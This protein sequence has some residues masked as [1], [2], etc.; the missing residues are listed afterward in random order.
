MASSARSRPSATSNRQRSGPT[1]LPTYQPPQHPLNENAIRAVQD[2]PR[3]HKL[4]SLKAR[5]NAANNHLAGAAV[6]INDRLVAQIALHEKSRARREKQGSQEDN[7]EEEMAMDEKRQQTIEL[8]GRLESGVRKIIDAKFEVEGVEKALREL[9]TNVANNRGAIAPTQSTLG[10]SQFRPNRRRRGGDADAEDSEDDT[11]SAG[12]NG[13]ALDFIK[14]KVAEQN[15]TYQ[16]E[17]MSFRYAQNNDYVGFKKLVYDAQF[18][19]DDA[20]LMPHSSTW[21]SDQSANMSDR[22]TR[23]AA[24]APGSQTAGNDDDLAVASERISTKCP[25]TLLPMKD[26]VTSTKCPHSFER[27]AILSMIDASDVR[28]DGSGRRGA[29][30]KKAMQC[31]VCTV[32]LTADDVAAN[33]VLVRKIQRIQAAENA[34]IQDDSDDDDVRA[35]TSGRLRP[36]EIGSSPAR[37]RTTQVKN[38]RRSQALRNKSREVSMVPNSQVQGLVNEGQGRPSSSAAT[39][40][41]D[42]EEDDEDEDAEE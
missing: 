5:L 40:V 27:E 10:A 41:V 4:D 34:Q 7:E 18:P 17:T 16:N 23:G 8:T 9:E 25:I 22:N 21:F 11:E 2:L 29:G 31:P 28:V 37:T 14:R 13:G 24:A 15:S 39:Q 12:E 42:L 38:E 33:P 32:M 36:E 35:P 1:P 30:G 19:G 3:N 6:D 26:P 20:P